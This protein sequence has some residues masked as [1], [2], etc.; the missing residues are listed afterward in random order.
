LIKIE[1]NP[2]IRLILEKK[3]E[4]EKLDDKNVKF[5]SVLLMKIFVKSDQKT[6]KICKKLQEN[7]KICRGSKYLRNGGKSEHLQNLLANLQIQ[8]S[9]ELAMANNVCHS[10]WLDGEL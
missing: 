3:F 1:E 2:N 4:K 5:L 8:I 6:Q 9:E 10:H 7:G